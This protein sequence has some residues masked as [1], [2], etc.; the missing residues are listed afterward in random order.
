ME[1]EIINSRWFEAK[2][3]NKRGNVA[4]WP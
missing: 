1:Q 3:G 2:L 4:C